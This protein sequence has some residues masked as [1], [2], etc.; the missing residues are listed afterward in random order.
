[1]RV[2]N[3]GH[4]RYGPWARSARRRS[5]LLVLVVVGMVGVA[6]RDHGPFALPFHERPVVSG[7]ESVVVVAERVD[8]LGWRA[9]GFGPVIT[10][11]VLQPGCAVASQPGAF[12]LL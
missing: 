6:P 9:V 2:E 5:L 4:H 11:V 12:R 7:F 1:M 10:V 3:D 8:A